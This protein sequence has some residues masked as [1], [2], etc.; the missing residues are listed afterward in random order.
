MLATTAGQRPSW[1]QPVLRGR[2]L[3]SGDGDAA[4]ALG[5]LSGWSEVSTVSSPAAMRLR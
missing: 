3:M 2:A 5:V 4:W 1:S